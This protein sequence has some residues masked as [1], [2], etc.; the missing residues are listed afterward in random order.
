MVVINEVFLVKF[1]CVLLFAIYRHGG[2]GLTTQVIL[3]PL[4]EQKVNEGLIRPVISNLYA[5]V[6]CAAHPAC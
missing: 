1:Y 4:N 5:I 2:Q 3:M 6:M